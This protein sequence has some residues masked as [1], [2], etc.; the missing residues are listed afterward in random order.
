MPRNISQ[1]NLFVYRGQSA[2][3]GVTLKFSKVTNSTDYE[4]QRNKLIK[5]P[6]FSS[7][8]MRAQFAVL[9]IVVSTIPIYLNKHQVVIGYPEFC[10]APKVWCLTSVG[11]AYLGWASTSQTQYSLSKDFPPR[12]QGLIT[13]RAGR[14]NPK[15]KLAFQRTDLEE[16]WMT[17]LAHPS[18]GYRLKMQ[19][20]TPWLLFQLLRSSL[21]LQSRLEPGWHH[22]RLFH[23]VY[24]QMREIQGAS[25]NSMHHV[26]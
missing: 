12:M 11:W 24:A 20:G 1:C 26:I 7:H 18:S 10:I 3:K 22:F 9:K 6:S 8:K 5:H 14:S 17:K 19:N 13:R 16:H 23:Y 2:W 21:L 15:S 25:G 4:L